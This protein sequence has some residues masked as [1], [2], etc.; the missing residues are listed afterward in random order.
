MGKSKSETV[1]LPEIILPEKLTV[2]HSLT[3]DWKGCR[4]K[5]FWNYLARLRPKK[6]HIPFFV[7]GFFHKGLEAF[8]NGQHPEDF[9]PALVLKMEAE[10]KK[11]VFI[12]PE[13][14][15]DLLIQSAIVEGMLGAY[16]IHYA[17]DRKR[18][19]IIDV[20]FRFEVPITDGISYVGSLDMLIEEDGKYWIVENKTAGR[21]DKN[22]VDRLP[23]DTQITG[24]AIGARWAKKVPIAG[25]IYNVAKKPQ[26]RIKVNESNEQF[27]SRL[28][29]D[30]TSRPEFYFYRE[31]LFRNTAAVNEYKAE[32]AE[33][34]ADINDKLDILK[35]VGPV[36]ALP[37]FYR[38]TDQCTIRGA[39]PYL[40]ICTKGW[41]PQVASWYE[42]RDSFNPELEPKEVEGE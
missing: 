23:L 38:N 41:N 26:L 17:K 25:V 18:W 11:A 7:G 31:Q 13:E 1:S 4:R 5:F 39:C 15:E 12:T 27:A 30:Y 14:E 8:Y 20:E 33:L 42:V 2:S 29:A 10:A 3:K 16:A 9:I 36:K 35:E 28:K 40:A 22:Y 34:A 32:I 6:L 24:Y 19:K 21:L 37:H